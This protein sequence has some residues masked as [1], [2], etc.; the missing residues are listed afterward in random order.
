MTNFTQG[1]S[2]YSTNTQT[3]QTGQQPPPAQANL[4]PFGVPAMLTNK[5]IVTPA[6]APW[7]GQQLAR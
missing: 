1:A 3:P 6:G 2:G 5:V 7:S 4:I